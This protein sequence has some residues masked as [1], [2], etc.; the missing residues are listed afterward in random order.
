M[1]A[2][3]AA[4]RSLA[5]D[6]AGSSARAGALRRVVRIAASSCTCAVALRSLARNCAGAAGVTCTQRSV[7]TYAAVAMSDATVLGVAARVGAR[8]TFSETVVAIAV[9]VIAARAVEGIP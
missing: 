6:V 9:A 7:S 1:R 3:A 8:P 2:L 5:R 4:L